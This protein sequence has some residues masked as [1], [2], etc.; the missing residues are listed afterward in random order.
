M[1][2]VL[3]KDADAAIRVAKGDEILAEQP[4]ADRRTVGLGDLFAQ[5]GGHPVPT[6]QVAHHGAG[7]G[8]RQDLVV[9]F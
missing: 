2:A 1:R 6:E 7:A 5:Q 4:K 3:A 9:A 8:L